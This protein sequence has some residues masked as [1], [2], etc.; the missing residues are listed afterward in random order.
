[1]HE[2]KQQMMKFMEQS[3]DGYPDR[4]L[5]YLEILIEGK[6]AS[7]FC[8]QDTMSYRHLTFGMTSKCNMNCTWCYRHDSA[9]KTT[10]DAMMPLETMEKIIENTEGR[11]QKIYLTGLGEPLLHP[12][13]DE[14]LQ[15]ARRLTDKV[16]LT[17]NGS[18][19]TEEH[20]DRLVDNGLTHIEVSIDAFDKN[21]Q[22]VHRGTDLEHLHNMLYYMSEMYD[23]QL[24]VRVNSVVNTIT[25][26]YLFDAVDYLADCENID[27][28]HIIPM[29]DVE[30]MRE[31]GITSVS[32]EDMK[33]LLE[34]LRSRLKHYRLNWSLYPSPDNIMIYPS[35]AM[36]KRLN[37]CFTCF[38]SPYIKSDGKLYPCARMVPWGGVD[39]TVGFEKAW[40]HPHLI[41]FRKKMLAGD[42]PEYCGK[43]CFLKEK[44]G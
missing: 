37:I 15:L 26:E 24:H 17:T 18:L 12:Q 3:F 42:Y 25:Y 20:I 33:H 11:F 43:L 21:V 39:A 19:L 10:L 4:L 7:P 14:A 6:D 13:Y 16:V 9:F 31:Q 27:V 40:N 41:E 23:E 2:K 28:Y 34:H 36:K 38:E 32:F 30:Q 1:M 22:K 8:W 35:I 29:Y 5:K 44:T